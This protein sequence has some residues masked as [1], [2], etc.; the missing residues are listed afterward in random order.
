MNDVQTIETT[1]LDFEA[2]LDCLEHWGESRDSFELLKA[3]I[4]DLN[5][6]V[7]D[8]LDR[9]EPF[10]LGELVTDDASSHRRPVADRVE[11]RLEHLQWY[12][13]ADIQLL[14]SAREGL[15]R[16][17]PHRLFDNDYDFAWLDV[18]LGTSEM[19]HLPQGALK[20][21]REE[22]I[23]HYAE[24]IEDL[25]DLRESLVLL[26][27]FHG[28]ALQSA[29]DFAV[30][31]PSERDDDNGEA[32]PELVKT[33]Y[34]PLN[35][36]VESSGSTESLRHEL[37]GLAG[38]A[39]GND[40]WRATFDTALDS[41]AA[42]RRNFRNRMKRAL[43]DLM[44]L[45]EETAG[46]RADDDELQTLRQAATLIAYRLMFLLELA[47]RGVLYNDLH[48]G[49]DL[50]ELADPEAVAS[51]PAGTLLSAVQHLTRVF[52]GRIPDPGVALE[53]ASIFSDRPTSDFD[54]E[55]VD[56]LRPLH[57]FDAPPSELRARFGAD[58]LERWDETLA[59][60]G[61][62][63]TGQINDYVQLVG[64]STGFGGAEHTH[65]V[66]GD[67]YEQ[68]LA[69]VPSRTDD[70][71]VELQLASHQGDDERSALGAHYTP[72]ELVEEVVRPALG[73]L[74][75][76]T[77]HEVDGDRTEY[78]EAIRNLSCVDPAMG[79][80][81]FLTV[82]ALEIAREL[83]YLEVR[84]EPRPFEIH[85]PLD[86]DDPFPDDLERA[87]RRKINESVR[88]SLPDVV[89]NCIHGVDLKPLA[90]ELGKLALWLFE[91]AVTDERDPDLDQKLTFL[92]TNIECGDSLV[93]VTLAEALETVRDALR[94]DAEEEVQTFN[95]FET[96]AD[97]LEDKVQRIAGLQRAARGSEAALAE[98]VDDHWHDEFGEP[99]PSSTYHQRN[100]IGIRADALLDEADWLYDLAVLID[101]HGY[102]SGSR[103][104]TARDFYEVLTGESVA[105]GDDP[106]DEVEDLLTDLVGVITDDEVDDP[107]LQNAIEHI[108]AEAARLDVFHWQLQYPDI[109][110][111]DADGDTDGGFDLIVANPPFIG[112]RD[113][114]GRIRP[115]G[116]VDYFADYYIKPVTG[117][118]S[119]SDCAGFFFHRY[120]QILGP[121]GVAGTL[122]PNSIAQ[123][124]N[125]E[126]VMKPLVL[127]EGDDPE[128]SDAPFHVLRALP[129][130]S[131]PGGANVHFCMVHFVR[132]TGGLPSRMVQPADGGALD[133]EEW[134]VASTGETGISSYLDEYPERELSELPSGAERYACQ[135]MILRGDFGIHKKTNESFEAAIERVPEEER[136]ALAAYLNNRDVQQY[137]RP[138]PSNVVIDFFEP[139][140]EAELLHASV[141]E[142]LEWLENNYPTL[143]DQ[144]RTQNPWDDTHE[145]I[146]ESRQKLDTTSIDEEH[147]K[148]WW[149]F[150]S[151][152]HGLRAKWDESEYL[153]AFGNVVKTWNPIRLPK[154][155]DSLGLRICPMHQWFLSPEDSPAWLGMVQSFVFESLVRRRCSSLKSDL[156]FSPTNVFP[157]FPV[158]WETEWDDEAGRPS[159]FPVPDDDPAVARIGEVASEL[160]DHRRAV[161]ENP[162]GHGITE[163]G[164]QW[165]PTKLYNLYDDEDCQLEAV[166]HLRQLHVD[167]LDAVLRAYGWDDLADDCQREDWT[168]DRPW[169]DRTPRFVPRYEQRG[170]MIER[171]AE[172]NRT[173][174]EHELS[175]YEPKVLEHLDA[176][177]WT[178]EKQIYEACSD[179]G[180]DFA[181]SQ[182]DERTRL[183]EILENLEDD[184]DVE[185]KWHGTSYRSWRLT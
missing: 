158:P 78:G 60:T 55:L 145:S 40:D 164:G 66:L 89:R 71:D 180:L 62:I 56:W 171:L 146:Y 115:E 127:G 41:E 8:N 35:E 163:T 53:G 111:F 18:D 151:P 139:L 114:R 113:L 88:Q 58:L 82:T 107:R 14:V 184:G 136:D 69:L 27:T 96:P 76:Q 38:L 173:R 49:H 3:L 90:C 7:A 12:D 84:G 147:K 132:D 134:S 106:K 98:W 83:A 121:D 148:Y 94:S 142:Q 174:Y 185:H 59:E 109:L 61:A 112:D 138:T 179:A 170:E 79:S 29:P 97:T 105:E 182:D 168:F 34:L 72:P 175:L 159:V 100:R 118:N 143:L 42:I 80:A 144:L 28:D 54:D 51:N 130:R 11:Q 125:R 73:H 169:I 16:N 101:H 68:I 131:W 50:R 31:G 36:R 37:A 48:E 21:V 157:Y 17:E 2:T 176:N 104:G 126:Y 165:G 119:K 160:V 178:T 47:S 87:E 166:E 177:T 32:Q 24:R 43:S 149:L 52:A 65:R 75:E 110:G 167:L 23:D 30:V 81:H 172:L 124:S 44:G 133:T 33:V 181:G 116:K 162:G 64:G 161:L 108:Q 22:C 20:D 150:G 77:W 13:D 63:V 67:V 128:A 26:A 123:A 93:G 45:L 137:P 4:G 183:A 6:K 92:D 120:N 153:T 129:N 91:L 135:G 57:A 154:H 39:A 70:G 5:P 86:Y 103:G 117:T 74:F 99:P 152:R 141:D 9:A 46:R 156:R 19:P 140:Q 85:E 1:D 102:S 15:A 10:N 155:L 122:G 95:L 25:R